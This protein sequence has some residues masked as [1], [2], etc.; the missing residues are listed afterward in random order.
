MGDYSDVA[1]SERACSNDIIAQVKFFHDQVRSF[2]LLQLRSV[3]FPSGGVVN[4]PA[5]SDASCKG[6]CDRTNLE[7]STRSSSC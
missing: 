3:F 2:R 6:G 7:E 1:K 5:S 4:P